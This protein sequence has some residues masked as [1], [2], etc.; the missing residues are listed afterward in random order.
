[1]P[2]D[3]ENINFQVLAIFKSPHKAG[4]FK[5][6]PR[7]YAALSLRL[8]GKGVFY[9]NG[10]KIV[11]NAG[12]VTFIPADVPYE[13][14]Y[15]V[16]ESIVVHLVECRYAKPLSFCV[17]N[18]ALVEIQFENL[19][20]TWMHRYS[21]CQIKA[22]IYDILDMLIRE[23]SGVAAEDLFSRCISYM[24]EHYTEANINIEAVCKKLFVSRS[25]LQR[26]FSERLGISPHQ[27][28]T[29]LRIEHSLTLLPERHLT[30]KEVANAC[31]FLDEKYFSTV[32]K[33]TYG[34]S[35][36]YLYDDKKM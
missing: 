23:Q 16:N 2:A 33:K 26:M 36:S 35:P 6:S 19:L 17:S 20:N 15:S 1:M 14:E 9:I 8:D 21:V 29:K 5:V 31:G 10:E 25:S 32:F 12:N 34:H 7:P 18:R 24:K 13:V 22:R 28:L 30:I 3:F 11:S 4:Y 27:Y